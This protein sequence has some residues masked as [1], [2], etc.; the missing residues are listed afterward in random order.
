MS[1][2]QTFEFPF[3]SKNKTFRKFVKNAK[4]E[5]WIKSFPYL[6]R[7][8][9]GKCH[10]FDVHFQEKI[11]FSVH[12]C[13]FLSEPHGMI[14]HVECSANFNFPIFHSFDSEFQNKFEFQQKET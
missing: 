7:E 2:F 11:E 14:I 9:V 6:F 5:K 3:N 1:T 4:N 12:S 10:K 8:L 13:R